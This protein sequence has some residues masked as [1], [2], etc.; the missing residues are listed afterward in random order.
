MPKHYSVIYAQ[1]GSIGFASGNATD[2]QLS[3]TQHLLLH[4]VKLYYLYARSVDVK[5]T[6]RVS[7]A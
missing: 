4:L 2:H 7:L 3:Y 1:D 5:V 6:L